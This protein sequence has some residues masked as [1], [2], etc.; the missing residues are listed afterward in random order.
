MYSILEYY[1]RY[2]IWHH[3]PSFEIQL[4]HIHLENVFKTQLI[5][6]EKSP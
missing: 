2:I 1:N 3:T 5:E 4:I 6:G